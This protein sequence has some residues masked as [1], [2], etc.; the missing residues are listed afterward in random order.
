MSWVAGATPYGA[1]DFEVECPKCHRTNHV[2]VTKQDGH[3]EPEEYAC[4]GCGHQL[5]K[6][7]ASLS[8]TVTL[9][10]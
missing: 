7:R 6:V 5:G 9:V 1:D 4:A 8:P 3:N 2:E 10:P